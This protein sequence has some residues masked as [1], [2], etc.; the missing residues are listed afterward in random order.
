MNDNAALTREALYDLV[1]SEPMLKVAARFGVSSSYMARV[2][3]LLYVPRPERGYWAKLAVGK[4]PKQP[5]LPEPRPGDPLEWSRDG[6]PPKRARPLPKPPEKKRRKRHKARTSLPDRH[7]LTTDAKP[8]FEAGRLS[9][10]AGYLKPAKRL[11]VDLA[12]TKTGLDKA[13]SFAN[14]LFLALETRGHRTLIAP[15]S[16]Q[17]CRAKVDERENP[18]KNRYY[19]NLWTPQRCT[20]VYIGTV[21]I[22][23]T[24]IEISEEVE[25]RYVN[26]EYVRLSDYVPKRRGRY[27]Q[28]SGWTSK[29]EFPTGRLCLQA[30]SPYPHAQWTQ[31]WRETKNR[32]LTA[33]IP[34]IVRELEKATVEVARLVEEGER[35]AELERQRWAAQMEQWEREEAERCAAKALKESKE[36]LF[37]IIETWAASKRLEE[38]FADAEHR[39]KNLPE[40]GR[41]RTIER[42]RRA[43]KLIGSTD[44]LN[45]FQSWKAPE[46]R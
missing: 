40:D 34:T 19:N 3:T 12:V 27:A 1:W 20:I 2:C 15:N 11:L 4:A 5:A 33:R 31:Q 37:E 41:T 28:D 8:L 18:E 22:G 14:Q 21:A 42:L 30:Y 43:R 39:L 9:Y 25:V 10:S 35:Q 7:P 24:I 29:H 36:E 45:R 6:T 23:L 13:L 44:A 38:F 16:E 17:F 46:E 26:G 32:G